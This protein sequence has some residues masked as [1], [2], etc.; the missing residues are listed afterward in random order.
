VTDTTTDTVI[1]GGE[2]AVVERP[3]YLPE[4][5]WN[6]EESSPNV[7]VLAKSYT[8]LESKFGQRASGL[9]EELQAEVNKPRE[10][11]PE[12][13][14][15]YAY[16]FPK[17]GLP[18]GWEIQTAE[19]DPML[20]WWKDTAFARG[21]TQDEFQEGINKYTEMLVSGVPDKAAEMKTLGDNA[22][23]RIDRV[24]LY[25]SKNLSEDEYNVMADFAINA[26]AI[27][28]LEKLIGIEGEPSI[29]SFGGEPST[30]SNSEDDIRAMMDDP[31]YWKP[32]EMDDGYRTKVTEMWQ[33]LYG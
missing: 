1:E 25:L 21:M 18:E 17:E 27:Q 20:G 6:T 31:R 28:V 16:E 24:D 19:D 10:G 29:S 30:G 4:K 33:K 12:S 32:G 3:E 23:E 26:D 8:E 5:F 22:Q 15:G 9:K 13:I 2:P 14:D 11:V 7:E